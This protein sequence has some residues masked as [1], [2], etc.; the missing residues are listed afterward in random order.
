MELEIWTVEWPK[1]Y[2]AL[3][4]TPILILECVLH[5]NVL[6]GLYKRVFILYLKAIIWRWLGQLIMLIAHFRDVYL[7]Y[8]GF[9]NIRNFTY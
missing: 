1:N 6:F 5:K 4:M 8:S 2:L 9:I 7:E 3:K